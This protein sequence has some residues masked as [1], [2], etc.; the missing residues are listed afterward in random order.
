MHPMR[1]T[2]ALLCACV[3]FL[4]PGTVI[5]AEPRV[6]E[7]V[8]VT[9]RQQ[10]ETLQDVPVAIAA[11][12]EQDLDRYNITTL[13]DASTLVPNFM[14]FQGGSGNGSNVILR[15]IG[16]SSISAA[17][18]QSVAINIDGV[19]VNIGRFIH[20]AYMDMG[21]IEVLKGP[22][23]L[24]FGKS[25]T[26]GVISVT[27]RDPGDEREFEVMGG[28]E[29][30]YDQIYS[31]LILSSPLTDT[32]G[33]RFAIGYTRS[34]EL[35][36]NLWPGVEN[37]WRGEEALNARLTVVYEPTDRFRA[38]L[39]YAY[40]EYENDGANGR[41]EEICPEGTVQ[42]TAVPAASA[43][44]VILPGIDDCKLNG[45]T[46]IADVHPAL[47]DGLPYGGDDGVP[48]LEQDTDFVA[49]QLDWD[50]NDH[51][52]LTSVTGWVDLEHIELDIYDY[53]AG[54]F[55]G[56]H[57]NV[58]ESLSQELRLASR[59]D[60]PLNFMLGLYYQD[61]EQVFNAYQYAFN[62]G[63]LFGP[64][65]VTGNEYDYNKNHFLDTE[66]YSAF[67]AGYWDITERIE[68]TAGLRYTDEQK[69]G[70]ITIPYLHAAAGA[71]GFGA[72]PLIEGLE[73]DDS[74]TSPEVAINWYLTDAVSVYASYKEGFKSGGIDNSALPTNS[75]DP[76]QNPDFPDFLL[77]DS[78]EAQGFEV[79]IKATLL[80][81]SM[82][83]NA[84]AF[85]YDY[86]N[87]QVQLFDANIIQFVTFNASKLTTEGVEADLLWVTPVEGLT[88]RGAL[89]LTDTKY[90]EDF[91]NAT[92]EN[93]KGED[94]A[95]SADIA[96]TLGLT[97]D[98]AVTN[99]WRLNFSFDARYNDGYP[100]SATLDPFEQDSYWVT[101][102]AVSL[103]SADDRYEL[104][105]I[106]RNLGDEIYALGAGPRPGA[107]GQAD[108]TNPDPTQ[109]CRSSGANDQDQVTTTSLGRQIT[110][111]FRVRF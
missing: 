22:Q 43:A 103:Y 51:L 28:Y 90:D 92:G 89:A 60:A 53:N 76:A 7:E 46:S 55:A 81:D 72:P 31:E 12:T 40:S 83:L 77:Y 41:T 98:L 94:G 36:E 79:G 37:E 27:T 91:I 73:F 69:D 16:S 96:G 108:P 39:K 100:I 75:L 42:P 30:E 49:L 3:G 10:Q 25:A 66:V 11:L 104:S 106:G 93:L 84:T 95:L 19:V 59:F 56:L 23:S 38:R 78:E 57:R 70:H 20:N 21:Q 74:N 64:D 48:F 54:V 9:A 63:L 47:R 105:L 67:L 26:A 13:T 6:I 32:L 111:Q 97:Y 82:R 17:F 87:L 88:L 101:D 34:D 29:T 35:F 33:A 71:F 109:R 65:P 107:C 5:G 2:R 45:N 4:V 99:D 1:P 18:D 8:I 24:Y 80:D 58:Y 110:L 15:G 61:V 102:A 44:L 52:A 86:D 62:L 14:V 85:S 68:L 50:V